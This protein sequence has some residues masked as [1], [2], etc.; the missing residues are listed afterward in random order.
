MMKKLI[1]M[2]LA[3]MVAVTGLAFA[4]TLALSPQP[5]EG[6]MLI[7]FETADQESLA[8][9]GAGDGTDAFDAF[10]SDDSTYA[11]RFEDFWKALSMLEPVQTLQ[12][13]ADDLG[14]ES[15]LDGTLTMV[16]VNGTVVTRIDGLESF[17]ILSGE[18]A[19]SIADGCDVNVW[20]A[21]SNAAT[22]VGSGSAICPRCGEI[23]DGSAKHDT[24]ISQFCEDGHTECMGDP[25]HHCDECGR[26][27][28]CSRSNSHTTC[29]KCGKAWCDKSEGDHAELACGHRGCEVYGEED[30]H[31]LCFVCGEYL[32][33]GEEHTVAECGEHHADEPLDHSECGVC[34]GSLCDGED[35]DHAVSEPEEETPDDETTGD[36]ITGDE[37]T[38]D[39]TTDEGES[40]EEA[41]S[42]GDETVDAA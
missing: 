24:L 17:A 6:Y 32:C 23:D 26:D 11:E 7:R 30:E 13:T 27:Y 3:L 28:A 22:V 41:P 12:A 34:G 10:A 20:T 29:A 8:L 18:G 42:E 36:E 19:P 5:Q 2:I 39:E 37:N 15:S 16:T 4:E 21:S 25:V 38:G 9:I 31:G 14:F 35:H 40:E 33:N 1:G